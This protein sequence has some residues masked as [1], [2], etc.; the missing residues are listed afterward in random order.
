MPLE[1]DRDDTLDAKGRRNFIRT[2]IGL[3]MF[4]NYSG[5]ELLSSLRKS[6]LG[7]STDDFYA[8]RR[9]KLNA[10]QYRNDISSLADNEKIPLGYTESKPDW[11]L[12]Q[13]YQYKT[14]LVGE[15]PLTGERIIK[16]FSVSSPIQLSKLEIQTSLSYMMQ[17]RN[18]FYGISKYE[19][20]VVQAISR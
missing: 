19:I 16:Y 5:S 8:I 9:E 6:G 7:I 17:G 20:E 11:E 14:R 15:D 1:F 2:Y 13:N 10:F 18:E 12:S 3:A 4:E